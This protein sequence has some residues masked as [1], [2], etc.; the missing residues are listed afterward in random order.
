LVHTAL[1][2]LERAAT[3]SETVEKR[4]AATSA[5]GEEEKAP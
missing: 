3:L 4:L 1:L 5:A 2:K